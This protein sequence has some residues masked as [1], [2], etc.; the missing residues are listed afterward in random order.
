MTQR[1]NPPPLQIPTA[2]G[3]DKETAAF[4]NTVINILSQMWKSLYDI[5]FTSQLKTTD[6]TPTGIVRVPVPTNRTVAI[7][8]I[9]VA[10]R[11]GGSAGTEG[12]SAYYYAFGCYKNINGTLTGIGTPTLF[13]GEDQSGWG[14]S[15]ASSAEDSVVI[16]TGAANNDITWEGTFSTYTVGA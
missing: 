6:D 9:I 13:G 7:E 10:R 2:F 12:D 15:F 5:R 14:V 1:Q 8:A 4:L 16:V 11:T 3:A